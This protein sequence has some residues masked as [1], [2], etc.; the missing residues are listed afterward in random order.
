MLSF[1]IVTE[2]VTP[3]SNG[4]RA[5][6]DLP[7]SFR[8]GERSVDEW[9]NTV[10]TQVALAKYPQET[11]KILHRDIFWF[12]LRHE[13]FVLKTIND[14]NIDLNEFPASKVHQPAKKMESSKVTF[15]HI[16]QVASDP[17]AIQNTSDVTPAH[18][19]IHPASS[20]RKIKP[21]SL[22][23]KT[24]GSLTM[25]IN[26]ECHNTRSFILVK[27]AQDQQ[28]VQSL[29]TANTEKGVGVHLMQLVT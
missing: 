2:T 10:Q 26:K 17:Q 18:R 11:A 21:S 24:T 19:I 1:R 22:D 12:S 20:K 14:S 5:G 25:K 6:F 8:Q 4:V 3:K 29:V 23:K 15:T 28:D 13:E 9:Y 16:K 27:N 7:I